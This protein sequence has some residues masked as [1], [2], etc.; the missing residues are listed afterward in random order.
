MEM[1]TEIII[2]LSIMGVIFCG[3][4][5]YLIWRSMCNMLGSRIITG[6]RSSSGFGNG[7]GYAQGLDKK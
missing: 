2:T 7:F 6:L 1:I 4:Y 3:I 5:A